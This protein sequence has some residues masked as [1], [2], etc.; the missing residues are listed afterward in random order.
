MK[1]FYEEETVKDRYNVE[2]IAEQVEKE[3]GFPYNVS[4]EGNGVK[5]VITLDNLL[6]IVLILRFDQM[7]YTKLLEYKLEFPRDYV[8]LKYTLI[9][10]E[11]YTSAIESVR[12]LN[13][14]FERMGFVK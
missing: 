10:L 13:D 14:L 2:E 4:E 9:A 5:L 1:I 8:D 7:E 6:N 3:Y 12:Q 11:S